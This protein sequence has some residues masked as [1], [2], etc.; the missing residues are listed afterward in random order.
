MSILVSG[1]CLGSMKKEYQIWR[2]NLVHKCY[3][4]LLQRYSVFAESKFLLF[5]SYA[6]CND[7]VFSK[8]RDENDRRNARFRRS[9]SYG[10]TCRQEKGGTISA[11]GLTV[12]KLADNI[13]ITVSML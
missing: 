6:C 12:L 2:R 11:E 9:I 10:T 4:T 8:P 5:S 3:T 7:S 13:I 1:G